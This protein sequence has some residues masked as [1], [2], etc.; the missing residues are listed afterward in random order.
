MVKKLIKFLVYLLFFILALMFFSPKISAY[1]FLESHIK[2]FG[3]I[4]SGEELH[5]NG[6]SLDIEHADVSFKAIDSAK[7]EKI[8]IKIYGLYNA[9]NIDGVKLSSTA[10][11]FIP[12][13]VTST[14]VYHTI[15]DPLI[16]YADAMGE[17]GEA[18]VRYDILTNGVKITLKPSKLMLRK[19]KNTLR[20][21]SKDENGEYIYEKTF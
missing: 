13:N 20:G 7:I 2:P 21:L 1:Y 18:E 8:N 5:D 14:K 6:F 3:V 15:F 10:A 11:S 17:F 9:V 16:V 4:I 19:Y 12:L